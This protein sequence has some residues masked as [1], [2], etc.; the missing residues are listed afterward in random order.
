MSIL[1][2][3]PFAKPASSSSD[4]INTI[5]TSI[6]NTLENTV[7]NNHD[8]E[9]DTES[10]PCTINKNLEFTVV[11]YKNNK[12]NPNPMSKS[13]PKAKPKPINIDVF[14]KSWNNLAEEDDEE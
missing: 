5:N 9:K 12:S 1:K 4:I 8:Q 6:E 7:S 2:K 11:Q 10:Q 13:K 14:N 3:N